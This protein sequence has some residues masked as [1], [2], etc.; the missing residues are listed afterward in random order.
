MINEQSKILMQQ[1]YVNVQCCYAAEVNTQVLCVLSHLTIFFY[2]LCGF[3][4]GVIK[5]PTT[6]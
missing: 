3:R 4:D 1:L 2:D 5:N 6:A